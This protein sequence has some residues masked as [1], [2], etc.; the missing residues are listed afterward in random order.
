VVDTEL[1]DGEMA[2]LHLEGKIYYSLNATGVRIWKCLKEGLT[3]KEISRSLQEEFDVDA[4]RADRS[5][6]KLVDELSQQ[7]LVQIPE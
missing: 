4:Q 2:L 6:L 7:K 5:V 1:D 3:L